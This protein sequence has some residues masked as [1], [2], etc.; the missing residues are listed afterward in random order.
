MLLFILFALVIGFFIWKA[1]SKRTVLDP[2]TTGWDPLIHDPNTDDSFMMNF[3]LAHFSDTA[4]KVLQP[5]NV[6]YNKFMSNLFYLAYGGNLNNPFASQDAKRFTSHTASIK[7]YIEKQNRPLMPLWFIAA[8]PDVLDWIQEAKAE[9][10]QILYEGI[11]E[12]DLKS[13]LD[14]KEEDTRKLEIYKVMIENY[15]KKIKPELEIQ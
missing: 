6:N 12:D 10:S 15:L 3:R 8:F 14:M 13:W 7:N 4:E 2:Q 11:R 9:R 1:V 5:L